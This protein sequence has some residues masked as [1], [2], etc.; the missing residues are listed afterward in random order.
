MQRGRFGMSKSWYVQDTFL[1]K[2]RAA[3][4]MHGF[5]TVFG[6][7]TSEAQANTI[8]S[9]DDRFSYPVV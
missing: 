5:E 4:E 3:L 1:C 9:L 8:W 2:R 7:A 6:S